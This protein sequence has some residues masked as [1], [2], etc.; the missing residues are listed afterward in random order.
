MVGVTVDKNYAGTSA[1]NIN[2]RFRASGTPD[3]FFQDDEESVTFVMKST[4]SAPANLSSK[5]LTL[6]G[7]RTRYIT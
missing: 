1:G 6:S 2:F 3:T 5:S 4:P 7:L